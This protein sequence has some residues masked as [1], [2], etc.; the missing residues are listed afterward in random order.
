MCTPG[1]GLGLRII[2]PQRRLGKVLPKPKLPTF[3]PVLFPASR[4]PDS[5]KLSNTHKTSSTP[6]S[7]PCHYG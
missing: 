7:G 4:I 2:T 1:V 5:L 6:E 3:S